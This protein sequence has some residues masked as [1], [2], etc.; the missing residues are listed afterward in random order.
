[1]YYL[2]KFFE[3]IGIGVITLAFYIN[4][5]NPMQYNTLLYGVIFFRKKVIDLSYNTIVMTIPSV[6]FFII[7]PIM[8][9]LKNNFIFSIIVSII[10]TTISYL[11]FI[12]IIKKLN[13]NF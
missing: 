13:F 11:I 4:Y 3:F 8:L 7:L 6:V 10:C 9:K 5:P 12:Y 2:A 1:M